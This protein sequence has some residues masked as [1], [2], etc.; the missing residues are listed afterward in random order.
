MYPQKSALNVLHANLVL[1]ILV[2]ILLK[3]F[4][5]CCYVERMCVD[6]GFFLLACFC[7]FFVP[8]VVYVFLWEC[9]GYCLSIS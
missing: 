8:D 2:D 3:M 5:K 6:G 7:C 9:F 4:F 1:F